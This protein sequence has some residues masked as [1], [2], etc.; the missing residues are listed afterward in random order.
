MKKVFSIILFTVVIAVL[1]FDLYFGIA[2]AIDV[3]NQLAELAA[4]EA[5]GHEY[6]GVGVD[7]VWFGVLFI[8]T[9][10]F[11]I[12]IISWKIAQFR[13]VKIASGVISALF[14]IPFG[15]LLFWFSI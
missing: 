6:L 10:G 4:R 7:I 14:L 2:G 3:K 13:V 8:S 15:A 12:A 5:S 1:L 11:I 9:V